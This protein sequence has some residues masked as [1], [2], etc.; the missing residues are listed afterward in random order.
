[1]RA[2]CIVGF[3]AKLDRRED[4]CWLWPGKPHKKT[5]YGRA[6]AGDGVYTGAHRVAWMLVNGPISDGLFV[7]HKCDNRRCCN[8]DHLFLG[9]AADNAHD[10][11]A[12]GRGASGERVAH[13][14]SAAQ[15]VEIR[16]L[17]A[18]GDTSL[19]QIGVRF[20]IGRDFVHAIVK[21]K[22]WASVA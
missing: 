4:G 21:R 13:R 16:Q 11:D 18:V 14:L 12:K 8:P 1:M 7:L 15:V 20:G 5:G 3:W 19:A 17:A 10:R 6:Y 2:D 22:K 9:T